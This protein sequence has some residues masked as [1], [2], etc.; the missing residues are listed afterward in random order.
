MAATTPTEGTIPASPA[1]GAPKPSPWLYGRAVDL[2]FGYGL[3]YVLSVPLLA[4]GTMS[5]ALGSRPVWLIAALA[6]LFSTPHYGATLLRVYDRRQ[7]RTRYAFFAVWI[8]L[9]LL[10]AF[11][12]G[13]YNAFIGSLLL[14]AY[15]TWS[16]WHFSGQN[17][18]LAVMYLRRSGIAFDDATKRDLYLSFVMSAV[19][20]ILAIHVVGS[21]LVFANASSD[22]SGVFTVQKLGLGRTLVQ[23]LAVGC[24]GVYLFYLF[25]AG[26]SLQRSAGGASLLP[27]LLLVGTQ[28]LWF[29]V[30]ALATSLTAKDLPA[31]LALPLSAWWIS[32]SHA[33]QYLWVT[34]FYAERTGEFGSF[35]PFLARCLFAGAF[36][37]LPAFLLL[38]TVLGGSLPN[39]AG[40]AVLVA[41]VV[42]LHHFILDGAIWKLRDGRIARALLRAEPADDGAGRRKRRW[43]AWSVGAA[44]LACVVAQ[45]YVLWLT[46]LATQPETPYV[47]LRSVASDLSRFGEDSPS[48]WGRVGQLAE[49]E[50]ERDVALAA[51]RR[52]V[53]GNPTPPVI[54]A[55]RMAWLL[56]SDHGDDPKSLRQARKLASYVTRKLGPA[57]PEGFQTL[58]AA[59]EAAGEWNAASEAARQGLEAAR[60]SGDEARTRDL[61]RRLALYER[62]KVTP[63]SGGTP[64]TDA[65]G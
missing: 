20:A 11:A 55:D 36:V 25:R 51:Y 61:E 49:A 33:I 37:T 57:R 34:W 40:I 29:A 1:G 4:W 10:V 12:A 41:S 7:D 39:A 8:T 28:G 56:I 64:R 26:R 32:T 13:L 6:L 23:G 47:T 52:V 27:V 14:T 3:A 54:A 58:A 35:P 17:Y 65:G 42:N 30:P 63:T 44:G 53:S 15:V 2:L 18:G 48:L 43:L 31:E 46:H 24:L 50:G 16:P 5:G 22:R 19:L 59:H 45:A 60:A 9:G 38:P 21:D 62:M